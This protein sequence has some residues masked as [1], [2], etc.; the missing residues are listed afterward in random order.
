MLNIPGHK[1]NSIKSTIR[2]HLIPARMAMIKN[3]NNH[4]CY[5]RGREGELFYIF[6]GNVN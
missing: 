2:F 1:G 3:T 4:T 6:G 5:Q